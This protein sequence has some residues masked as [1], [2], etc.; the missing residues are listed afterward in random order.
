MSNL[1]K[2]SEYLSP[3]SNRLLKAKFE[4]HNVI[5]FEKKINF[6]HYKQR[7]HKQ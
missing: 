5:Y 1:K 2:Y 6:I 3:A 4:D 7:I